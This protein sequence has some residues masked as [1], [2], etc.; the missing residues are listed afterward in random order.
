MKKILIVENNPIVVKVWSKF[1]KNNGYEVLFA[2][3]A[4]EAITL[5]RDNPADLV[6]LDLRLNGITPSG[7]EVFAFMRGGSCRNVPVTFITGLTGD[8]DLYQ[9]AKQAVDNDA[10]KG[11]FT[12][13]IQKPIAIK[14][15]LETIKEM[16]N[17]AEIQACACS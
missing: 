10:S 3:H 2:H 16:E 5:L 6:L 9:Q 13:I 17:Y 4:P 1:F 12:R 11:I 15:L 8:T 7:M 14:D